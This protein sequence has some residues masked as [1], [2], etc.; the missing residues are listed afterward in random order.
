MISILIL[1]ILVVAVFAIGCYIGTK[2]G[3]ESIY[4]WGEFRYISTQILIVMILVG[5]IA[6]I[7]FIAKY[8]IV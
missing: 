3:D 8:H 4:E 7:I 5:I 2:V 1:V 6:G